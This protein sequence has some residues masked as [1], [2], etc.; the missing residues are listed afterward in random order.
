MALENWLIDEI[1]EQREFDK[2]T[3]TCMDSMADQR[4]YSNRQPDR[5]VWGGPPPQGTAGGLGS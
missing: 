2:S 5:C 4:T 1:R 3:K